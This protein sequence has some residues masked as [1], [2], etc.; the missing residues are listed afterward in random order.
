MDPTQGVSPQ[1][2]AEMQA[3]LQREQ[4]M[5]LVQAAI[6]RLTEVCWDKCIG[7]D[8]GKE[9]S[10]FGSRQ[11]K[12]ISS[13]AVAYLRSSEFVAKRVQAQAQQQQGGGM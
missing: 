1:M 5:L 10:S 11:T 8:N 3:V 13:T 4:Q 7:G 12:C 9:D 2:Q 6:T